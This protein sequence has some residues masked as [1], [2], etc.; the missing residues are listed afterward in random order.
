MDNNENNMNEFVVN[1]PIFGGAPKSVEVGSFDDEENIEEVEMEEEVVEPIQ[2]TDEVISNRKIDDEIKY[3]KGDIIVPTELL[4]SMVAQARKVG[5]ANNL[6]PISE[7]L[8]L[9][10]DENGIIVRSSSGLGKQDYECIDRRYSFDKKL[11]VALDIVRFS[12]YLSVERSKELL[13]DYSSTSDGRGVLVV[14]TSSGSRNF[15]QRINEATGTPIENEIHMSFDYNNMRPV[16]YANFKRIF[17]TNSAVREFTKHLKGP[18]TRLQGMY[19][20]DDIIVATD[21]YIMMIQ[22][23]ET[24]FNDKIFF[25]GNEFC[26]LLSELTFNEDSFRVGVTEKNGEVVG[27]TFSDGMAT[28]CGNVTLESDFPVEPSK[29]YWSMD[30]DNIYKI[31]LN[32]DDF[33]YAVKSI[34]SSVP[35]IGRYVDSLS[36][37]VSGNELTV[38]CS[39]DSAQEICNVDNQKGYVTSEPIM[40]SASRLNKIIS[41]LN[42]ENIELIVNVLAKNYI[43]I[44]CDS[45]RCVITTLVNNNG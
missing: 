21:G 16:N 41:S 45:F 30:G 18:F 23:N 2:E 4:R 25:I 38:K 44:G 5:V 13:L 15:P 19:W 40:L 33:T 14:K 9:I 12:K 27:V 6:Y 29:N 28:I 36:I 32:K 11:S 17:S 20:G 26:K 10:I 39:D 35:S 3:V 7:V 8:N 37:L 34:M 43:I 22:P 42:F 31:K 24:N 1:E